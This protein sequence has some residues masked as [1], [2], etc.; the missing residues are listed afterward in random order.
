M[1][2]FGQVQVLD[3]AATDSNLKGFFGGFSDGTRGAMR[4]GEVYW[5]SQLDGDLVGDRP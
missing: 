5:A 4:H 1:A 3:L 2:S